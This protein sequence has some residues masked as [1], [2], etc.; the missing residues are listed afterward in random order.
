MAPMQRP[1]PLSATTDLTDLTDHTD[2]TSQ[3]IEVDPDSRSLSSADFEAETQSL[4][5]SVRDVLHEYGRTYQKW[6]VGAYPFPND[7]LENERLKLQHIIIRALFNGRNWFAPINRL[8]QRRPRRLLDIGCGTGHW[9]HEM[10]K[11]FPRTRV[12]GIDLTPTKGL[13]RSPDNCHLMIDD[14]RHKMWWGLANGYTYDYIHTRMS[15]GIFHDF[16]E[17]IQKGFNNLEP[18]GWME[19]Q[20]LD[21]KVYCDDGTMPENWPLLEW[22]KDQDDAATNHLETPLRIANKLK[23]WY[24]QAGFVEVKEEVFHIPINEWAKEDR[25][26]MFGKFMAQNMQAGLYGWSVNYFNRAWGWTESEIR[27]KL[28]R[29]HNSLFDKTVHAYYKVYVVYGRK[30]RIGEAPSQVPKP[31][32]WPTEHTSRNDDADNA[33]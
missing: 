6:K 4:T 19:S 8:P 24:E 28:A 31:D 18:G 17:I 9:C 15:L 11:E 12:E 14:I 13:A 7:D 21:S 5:P 22:S 10:A 33:C 3:A 20:E 16:R 32:H 2:R 1:R 30:P 29:V 25:L 26:K 23:R 27:V